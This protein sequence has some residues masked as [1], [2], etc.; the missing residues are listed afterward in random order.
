MPTASRALYIEIK[1]CN[2]GYSF[3]YFALDTS[4]R[5]AN[6]DLCTPYNKLPL[7]LACGYFNPLNEIFFQSY[8]KYHIKYHIPFCLCNE[9]VNIVIVEESK[10]S[11]YASPSAPFSATV[12]HFIPDF[13]C[14]YISPCYA[15]IY[16]AKYE[17]QSPASQSPYILPFVLLRKANPSYWL[18]VSQWMRA[19]TGS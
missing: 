5:S 17:S 3:N 16:S 9:L 10:S 13:I 19:K 6:T 1:L 11:H 15:I 2:N 4:K 7:L 8:L 18:A 14:L 12:T